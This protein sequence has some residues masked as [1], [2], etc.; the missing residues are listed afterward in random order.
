MLDR[1]TLGSESRYPVLSYIYDNYDSCSP[2][3]QKQIW[4]FGTLVNTSIRDLERI[5]DVSF[6]MRVIQLC[7]KETI[8]IAH[9]LFTAE[10]KEIRDRLLN[11]THAR[12]ANLM[13]V[14]KAIHKHEVFAFKAEQRRISAELNKKDDI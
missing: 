2:S 10:E 14:T 5:H 13:H 6:R 9:E 11:F 8:Q 3:L 7:K 4:K 1:G 12:F